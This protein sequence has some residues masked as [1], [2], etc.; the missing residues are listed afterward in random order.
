[1]TSP[2]DETDP[3]LQLHL[4]ALG[5]RL[6][7]ARRA[8]DVTQDE[9]AARSGVGRGYIS[10]TE[11]GDANPTVLTLWRLA[12]A[13]DMHAADLLRDRPRGDQ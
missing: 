12:R 9:L 7:A 1:M 8:A 10:K 13:L 5:S 6:R 11:H 3:Q 4:Q 2:E